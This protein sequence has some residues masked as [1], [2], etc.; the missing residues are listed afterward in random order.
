MKKSLTLVLASALLLGSAQAQNVTLTV[1]AF[2]SLDSAIKAILPAWNKLHPNVTIKLQA[3]E[4]ADHH[5]AMTTAL[6]TG[7]GLPDVMAIE[8]GF[9]SKFAEG[10]GLE[11][12]DN[13]PYNAGQYKKL[14]TPFTIGQATSSDKRF[15]AMPTDIG[16]GTFFY[17]KDVLDKA[18]VNPLTLQTS[19]ESFIE[20]GKKIKAKTGAYLINTAASINNVIIRTNL[21]PGEGIYF[22]SKNNLLVGPDNA[23]FVRAFTLSKQVRDAGLDA[24][25]GEWSNEW[26]DAFKKGTV[27][28]QFSG[29]WLQGALQNWMAPDTKGLWRV[30]NLPEKGFASWGG[31]FYAIPS[32]AVN[33]QWA[34][35]FI[36]F[37]TLEQS[38]QITAFKDNGAFPALLAAQKDKAFS[39]AVPFLGGQQARVLW[40][41]AAAKTQPIDVNKYDSV[42]EQIVQ[43]ELTNVL[44][45]GKD[46]KQAL[47]DARAQIA[48]RAR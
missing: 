47:S 35:E 39:E 19:W 22:D 21:K 31:S 37:M 30:Q 42:A 8:I 20:G 24:K 25:I 41:D 5:N 36:K 17:R 23:R 14:F 3:Q 28:T 45:Q 10:Q 44:E 13:A 12:L 15:I 1:A 43:T 34:W 6:A 4:Y 33:K 26:Y 16:P 9:V 7:Q 2:P 18:G 40:R 46:I 32:K 11:N 29:A 27:A 38:S 48:R